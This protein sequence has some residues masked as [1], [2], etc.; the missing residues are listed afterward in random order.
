MAPVV[1]GSG[2]QHSLSEVRVKV[3]N[4]LMQTTA[5]SSTWTDAILDDCIND[6]LKY[7]LLKGLVEIAQD[8]FTT[9]ADQQTWTPADTVWKL[10]EINCDDNRLREMTRAEMNAITGGDWDRDSGDWESWFMHETQNDR[11]VQFDKKAPVNKTVK[12]WFWRCPHD[13]TS[14]DELVGMYRVLTPLVVEGALWKAYESDGNLD[15]A[16]LHK[17]N[18]AEMIPDALMAVER[19]HESDDP[20]IR[21]WVGSAF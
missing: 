15:E 17:A 11:E 2:Y 12:F 1:V 19:L 18:L 7:M 14:N 13:L 4:R 5:A 9:T 3:R 8:T 16:T 6:T 21:D 10:V 20:V